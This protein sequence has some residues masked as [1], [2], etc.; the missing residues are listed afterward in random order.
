MKCTCTLFAVLVLL[1]TAQFGAAQTQE[2]K[3]LASFISNAKLLERKP[4]DKNAAAAREWGFKWLVETNQVSVVLCEQT[5]KLIPEKKNKFKSELL[6]HFTFGQ[7]VFKLEN[8]NQK[9][10]ENTAQ[11]AGIESMLRTYEQMVSEN[12]KA[13]NAELDGLIVKRENGELKALVESK[14]CGSKPGKSE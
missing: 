2:E 1:L 5:M 9:D 13:R 11:L 7:A 12:E 6:M 8:P 3:D 4:F 10:D 14:K